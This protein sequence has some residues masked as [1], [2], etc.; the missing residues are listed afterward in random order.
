VL[1]LDYR[2]MFW[3]SRQDATREVERALAR[4]TVAIGN[5]E[6]CEVAV[7]ETDPHRA[8]DALLARGVEL[9]IVK[10]GP[11]G[12]LAKTATETVEVAPYPV[13]VVNGLGSGDGFGGALCFALLEGFPL[14]EALHFAN[15][16]GAI[17]ATRLECS[18]AMPT[19]AEVREL[20]EGAVNA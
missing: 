10:M 20:M 13:D 4:V 7:G 19:T 11:R 12:A 3:D 18:T 5:K 14:D 2:P 8:A 1:D 6:E 17:V 16:A 15:A 9:A